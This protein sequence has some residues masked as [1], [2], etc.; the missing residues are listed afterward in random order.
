MTKSYDST[1]N[2][3]NLKSTSSGDEIDVNNQEIIF[4][5]N[6]RKRMFQESGIHFTKEVNTTERAVCAQLMLVDTVLLTGG[7]IAISTQDSPTLEGAFLIL[8]G[9]LALVAILFS[10]VCGIIYY[11]TIMNHYN[12]HAKVK[13][14]CVDIV[15][16]S[17]IKSLEKLNNL[18]YERQAEVPREADRFWLYL[19]VALTI[20]AMFLSAIFFIV[21]FLG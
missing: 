11:F 2:E 14:E 1:D 13:F 21:L 17:K 12:R 18:L 20:S 7:F 16:D 15:L 19:Q 8:L 5:W 4:Y 10:V 9:I 3:P 6:Q